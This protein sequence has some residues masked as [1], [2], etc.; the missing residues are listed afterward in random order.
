MALAPKKV[1]NILVEVER[2][3]QYQC[4]A[5]LGPCN[6]RYCDEAC[7]TRACFNDYNGLNPLPNCDQ[8]PGLVVR[9]CSCYHDCHQH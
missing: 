7:C 1:D 8:I 4:L 2:R 3:Q 9:L 6:T 5:Q